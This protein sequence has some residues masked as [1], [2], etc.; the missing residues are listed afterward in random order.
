MPNILFL[1]DNEE[2]SKDLSEQIT[3]Y[4]KDFDVFQDAETSALFDVIILDEKPALYKDLRKKYPQTP[5]FVLQTEA[6][7]VN[8]DSNLSL[9]F[10][11]PLSLDA[12]LNKLK[13]SINILENSSDGY[14]FFNK[15]EL[16]PVSKD[17]LN[18]RNN[19]TI[20]LTEKEVSIIKY[21]Y[22]ARDKI[23]SKNELLQEV[24]GYSPDVTTHTIET[25]IYRLRQKVEHE[26]LNAQ[27]ILTEDGGY[28]LKM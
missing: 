28:K 1:S 26:D 22:K 18:T 9:C 16:H 3:L 2:F 20:K 21:L 10:C 23:V 25:H 13:S 4:A 5:I 24:W 27:L 17:I 12:F 14:L 19:E 15:Y 8:E 7:D 11:K 6:C